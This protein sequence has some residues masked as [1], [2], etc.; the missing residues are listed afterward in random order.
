MNNNFEYLID[1]LKALP[2]VG[3]KQAKN[4]AYFLLNKDP[5]F[6]EEFI[7]RIKN[8]KQA[9]HLCKQCNNYT[10]NEDYCDICKDFDRD[11]NKLCIVTN[12]E[13]LNKIEAT[14]EY[15]GL[16]Y[17]LME[18]YDV[19]KNKPLPAQIVSKLITLLKKYKF[20][21]ITIATS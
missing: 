21:E 17:V 1:A 13:E 20:Q 15:N 8:A 10:T 2:G 14:K 4:I 12:S 7:E 9:I 5:M 6:I 3:A 18:E 16:Y 11:N 19:K